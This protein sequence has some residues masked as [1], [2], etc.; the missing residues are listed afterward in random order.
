MKEDIRKIISII[1]PVFN[2]EGNLLQ[3]NTSLMSVVR[4]MDRPYEII[5]VDDGSLDGSVDILTAIAK[6]HPGVKVIEFDKNYGQ[7]F[8]FR[9]GLDCSKGEIIIFIDSDL[10]NDPRDI[11]K[12]IEKIEEGYDIVSGWRKERKDN[13]VTRVIP[14][15]MA[16]KIISFI[17]GIKLHDIGCSLKAY[18]RSVLQDIDFYGEIHRIIPVYAFN[19]GIKIAEVKVSHNYRKSG[20][21]KYGI[22]RI[23]KLS[24]DMIAAYFITR[25]STKPIYFF[26]FIGLFLFLFGIL[27]LVFSSIRAIFFTGIGVTPLL[28]I[29]IMLLLMGVQAILMGVLAEVLMRLYYKKEPKTPYTISKIIEDSK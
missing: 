5:Y 27:V 2:E 13:L 11:P 10:Q 25:Y 17:L 3:F 16:N 21:S 24:L 9:A 20:T 18:K 23:F 1:M 12:L 19:H 4:N 29:S 6:G 28:F 26:G 22:S 8:A 7:T 15:I 14:S